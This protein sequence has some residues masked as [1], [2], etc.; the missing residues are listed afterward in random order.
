[1]TRRR[2]WRTATVAAVAAITPRAGAAQQPAAPAAPDAEA[3]VCLGFR[4]GPWTPALNWRAAGHGEAVDSGGTPRAPRGRGWAAPSATSPSDTAMML[5]P[6][7]WPVG[8]IVE[9]ATRPPAAGD[10]VVGRAVA[11]VN[12]ARRRA[13]TSRVRAWQVPCSR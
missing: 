2:L 12:D 10:T 6:S 3:S 13:P 8:I 4:F 7:W 5:F 9:L 11:L 1:V